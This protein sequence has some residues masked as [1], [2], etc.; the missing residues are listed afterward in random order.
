MNT[1]IRNFNAVI[2]TLILSVKA[3]HA[4]QVLFT[5][6]NRPLW[7]EVY[8]YAGDKIKFEYSGENRKANVYFWGPSA[9]Y[10]T[11]F[12]DRFEKVDDLNSREWEITKEGPH[13]IGMVKLKGKGTLKL[14]R[15]PI[16]GKE[17]APLTYMNKFSFT[18]KKEEEGYYKD[19]YQKLINNKKTWDY[20]TSYYLPSDEV[21]SKKP[22]EFDEKRAIVLINKSFILEPVGKVTVNQVTFALQKGDTVTFEITP[23]K[24]KGEYN[25]WVARPDQ[26]FQFNPDK[27]YDGNPDRYTIMSKYLIRAITPANESA[28]GSFVV[29]NDGLISFYFQYDGVYDMKILRYTGKGNDLNFNI[30][31]E[32]V[33]VYRPSYNDYIME[34]MIKN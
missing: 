26:Y 31:F 11:E 4:Q 6:E 3:L 23:K 32:T 30:P 24:N 15:M 28:K 22:Q 8:L 29:N 18:Y 16:A 21:L 19:H 20:E 34:P 12:N 33:P 27:Y 5:A 10:S 25:I 14:I 7:K 2:F 17:N 13:T 1:I 9:A